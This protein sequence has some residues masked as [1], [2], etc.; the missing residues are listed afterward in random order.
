MRSRNART[1]SGVSAPRPKWKKGGSTTG[2]S[3]WP[4]RE[5]EAGRV[6]EDAD[7]V[8]ARLGLRLEAEVPLVEANRARLVGDREREVVH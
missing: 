5:R 1:S 4:M 8:L 7:A 6:V 2:S 3:I